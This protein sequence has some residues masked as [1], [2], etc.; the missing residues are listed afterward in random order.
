MS[1]GKHGVLR[2]LRQLWFCARL[3]LETTEYALVVKD[4]FPFALW[5]GSVRE[6]LDCC[7]SQLSLS[8]LRNCGL[9]GVTLPIKQN[10]CMGGTRPRQRRLKRLT[11]C[12]PR[13]GVVVSQRSPNRSISC[14]FLTVYVELSFS[15]GMKPTVS[16]CAS[17]LLH[18]LP[19]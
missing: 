5:C 8:P 14:S 10:P 12:H 6:P 19:Q 7:V 3:I 17:Q 1:W 15:G 2:G 16:F 4:R 13:T 18:L 11:S 9:D